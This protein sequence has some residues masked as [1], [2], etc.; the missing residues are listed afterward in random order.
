VPA[1]VVAFV[2]TV[3]VL[4]PDGVTETGLN[5]LVAPEGNPVALKATVPVK[6]VPAVTIAVKVVLAPLTTVLEAGSAASEKS[7]TVIVRVAGVALASPP[8]SVTVSDA[9]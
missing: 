4:E 9:V 2:V 1:G 5:D 8:L 7:V 3:S 6:P